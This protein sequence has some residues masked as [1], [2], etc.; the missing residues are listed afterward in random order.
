MLSSAILSLLPTAF[1]PTKFHLTGQNFLI[2]LPF[3]KLMKNLKTPTSM[4]S[5]PST[6][7]WFHQILSLLNRNP[8]AHLSLRGS[9]TTHPLL[10]GSLLLTQLSLVLFHQ[11]AGTH[12]IRT[13]PISKGN[14][15]PTKPHTN[16]LLLLQ[17]TPHLH[18]SLP[19][20]TLP[21]LLLTT[22]T[23]FTIV[24]CS[25]TSIGMTIQ[26]YKAHLCPHGGMQIEVINFWEAYA[27]VE[28]LVNSMSYS[29]PQPSLWSQ[30]PTSWLGLSLHPS[31]S[32]LWNLLS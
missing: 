11:L 18:I 29:H 32:Q 10:R 23:Y 31:T 13:T 15:L 14:I 16:H 21:F 20:I 12:P 27:P 7:Q 2:H 22:K 19:T 24:K 25:R 17:M 1:T 30:E 26:K 4:I 6:H 9:F 3:A 5:L 8:L 28:Q